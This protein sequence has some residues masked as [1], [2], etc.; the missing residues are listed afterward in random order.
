MATNAST[1]TF[2][3]TKVAKEI[4]YGTK[5]KQKTF[6]MLMLIT[7]LCQNYLK[8]RITQEVSHWIFG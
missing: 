4:C 6:G 3:Q 5:Q 7:Q 8:Q 1:L 2:A